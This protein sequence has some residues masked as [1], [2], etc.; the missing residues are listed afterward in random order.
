MNPTL[1]DPA[2]GADTFNS[3]AAKGDV[4]LP[5]VVGDIIQIRVTD[6]A[7]RTGSAAEFSSFGGFMIG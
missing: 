3:V 4:I 5:C 6:G 7:A 1:S 2:V